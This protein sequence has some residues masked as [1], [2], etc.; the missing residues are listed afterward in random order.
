M[1]RDDPI[2]QLR[3]LD[4]AHEKDVETLVAALAGDG[5]VERALAQPR[6]A[7][8]RR[9]A[10]RPRLALIAIAGAAAV[11]VLAVL[12]ANPFSGSG[13]ISSAQAKAQAARALDLNLD[14]GWHITR[15]TQIG[16]ATGSGKPHFSKPLIEDAWHA[17]DGRLLVRTAIGSGAGETTFFADGERRVYDTTRNTLR[18]HRFVLAADMRAEQRSLLPPTAA[19][20]YRAAYQVGKVRLAGIETRGGRQVYRLAFDWLGSSYTL[21]FDADRRVP[22][23]SESRSAPNGTNHFLVTRVRYTAYR[24]VP[25]GALLD[26]HLRLP[27]AATEAK[28][29]SDPPLV[30]PRPVQGASAAPFVRALA[31]TLGG[32]FPPTARL[33]RATY[34]IVRGL[35]SGGLIA[36]ARIPNPGVRSGDCYAVAEL[37]FAHGEAV[38]TAAGCSMGAIG[39]SMTRDGKTSIL[40]GLTQA[41]R[42]E[43]HFDGG[44]TVRASLRHG[45]FLAAFPAGL[46]RRPFSVVITARDGSVTSHPWRVGM[47][48]QLPDPT[49]A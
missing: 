2:A 21:V 40:T 47:G 36:V 28:I 24:S 18:V 49:P 25:S 6:P 4:P 5:A 43:L 35:P 14:G 39:G 11:V 33:G 29:V 1:N 22:I 48:G 30:I 20:L 3:T 17:P 16:E 7:P 26:S 13:G 15:V 9:R 41:R 32:A 10:R 34:A 23:S 38:P 27:A 42:V 37:A 45:V 19:D 12:V 8:A 31:Q 44:P 46:S